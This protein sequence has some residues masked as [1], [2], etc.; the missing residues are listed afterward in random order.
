MLLSHACALR[1]V[2]P[3]PSASEED[4]QC[5]ANLSSC[6]KYPSLRKDTGTK[7]YHV[8]QGRKKNHC[9]SLNINKQCIYGVTIKLLHAETSVFNLQHTARRFYVKLTAEV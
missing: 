1:D 7:R 6:E 4:C 8:H 5:P 2:L 3:L 9:L